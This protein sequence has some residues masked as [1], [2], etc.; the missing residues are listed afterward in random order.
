MGY[1]VGLASREA[2]DTLVRKRHLG[3]AEELRR[4]IGA[5]DLI[6]RRRPYLT[7]GT[8]NSKDH[9]GTYYSGLGNNT[10]HTQVP[11]LSYDLSDKGGTGH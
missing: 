1:E 5:L 7:T 10:I 8:E 2:I 9:I 4:V 11:K 3:T 6:R